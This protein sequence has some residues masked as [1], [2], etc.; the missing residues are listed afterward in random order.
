MITYRE[1]LRDKTDCQDT[2]IRYLMEV[3][4]MSRNSAI[5]FAYLYYDNVDKQNTLYYNPD[6]LDDF[7]IQ[8]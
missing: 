3:R 1:F 8:K 4:D 7:D 6:I 5:P 2:Y